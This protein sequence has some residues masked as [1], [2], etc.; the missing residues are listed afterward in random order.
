MYRHL[1]VVFLTINFVFAVNLLSLC[2]SSYSSSRFCFCSSRRSNSERWSYSSSGHSGKQARSIIYNEYWTLHSHKWNFILF[3]IFNLFVDVYIRWI[4][5]MIFWGTYHYKNLI[6]CT[7]EEIS[8]VLMYIC[9]KNA[10]ITSR[11][12]CKVDLTLL[13]HHK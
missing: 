11:L 13:Q 10:I 1:L 5:I 3:C 9:Y 8:N 12:S 4:R 2:A 7:G 6:S